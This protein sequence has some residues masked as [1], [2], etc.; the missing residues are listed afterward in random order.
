MKWLMKC[1]RRD[2]KTYQKFTKK[3]KEKQFQKLRKFMYDMN[4]K[5]FHKTDILKRDQI[6]ILEWKICQIK[7]NTIENLDSRL[8]EAKERISK[9]FGKNFSQTKTRNEV[10]LRKCPRIMWYDQTTQQIC[11]WSSWSC[12]KIDWIKAPIE[13]KDKWKLC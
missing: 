11:F 10:K 12:G 1:L 13:W 7:K 6:E 4:K 8:G 3:N 2:R 5:F 9:I